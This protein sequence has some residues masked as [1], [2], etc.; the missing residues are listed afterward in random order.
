MR[1]TTILKGLNGI[2][3]YPY[4][5]HAY[6]NRFFQVVYYKINFKNLAK[7]REV[8]FQKTL[9]RNPFKN[10]GS[11]NRLTKPTQTISAIYPASQKIRAATKYRFAVAAPSGFLPENRVILPEHRGERPN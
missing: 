3:S 1:Q 2:I 4:Y 7:K 6:F 10:G 11:A 8:L 9:K 5:L